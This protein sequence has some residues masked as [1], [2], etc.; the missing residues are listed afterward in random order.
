M[1]TVEWEI[2]EERLVA[3]LLDK[4]DG[5]RGDDIADVAIRPGPLAVMTEGGVE[6]GA[7]FVC[8]IGR[9]ARLREAAAIKDER[10]VEAFVHGPHRVVVA[11]VPF[12][13]Y[14]SAITARGEHLRERRLV[15]VH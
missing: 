10:F 7:A 14:P 1:R 6:V 12:A 2:D 5:R 15:R 9:V 4:L 11:E 3:L 13:E 8:R